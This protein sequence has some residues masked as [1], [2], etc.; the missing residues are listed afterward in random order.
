MRAARA[1]DRA[2]FAALYGPHQRRL[3]ACC[4]RLL[5]DPLLAEEVAQQTMVEALLGLPRLAVPERFGPWLLGIAAHL[6]RRCLR[7][8]TRRPASLE[9]L[10]AAGALPEP[11]AA[12]PGPA[13]PAERAELAEAL[14]GAV[15]RLPPGQHAAVELVYLRGLTTAEAAAALGIAVGA[16]KARLHKGRLALRTLLAD[17]PPGLRP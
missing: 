1:G 14:L 5:G 4:R 3:L 7:A 17:A 9:A 8:P 6:C 12:G 16:V 10:R 13:G 15:A 2:A 11:A